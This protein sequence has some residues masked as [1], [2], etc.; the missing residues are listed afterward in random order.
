MLVRMNSSQCVPLT[1]QIVKGIRRLV[2]ERALRPGTCLPSIRQFAAA[3]NVSKVTVVS[4]YD[5]LVAAGYI[6]SRKNAGFFV[7]RPSWLD[8][9]ADAD[10]QPARI[11][12]VLWLLRKQTNQKCFKHR[13]GS[14]WLPHRWMEESGLARA[15]RELGRRE[16][17]GLDSGYGDPLGYAPLRVHVTR[18]LAELGI[19]ACS[20]QVLLTG[21]IT[22]GI[23]LLARFL[24]RPGD[25]VLVDDPG[26]YQWFAH[27]RALGATVHGVRWTDAGPDLEQLEALARAHQPRLFITTPIVQNP[28]GRSISQRTAFRLLQLAERHNFFIVEDDAAAVFHPATPPRLASLDQLNRVV[29]VNSFS[30]FLSPRLRV[31]F[32]A[33]HRDLVRDLADLKLVTQSA[34]SEYTERLICEV[35]DQGNY[36][37]FRIRLLERIQKARNTA[38]RRLEDLGFGPAEDRTH[39]LFAWLEV[40]GIAD[41]TAVAEAAIERSMLLAP[42]ALFRPNMELSSKMR[43]N[44]AFCQNDGMFR[45]LEA[46]L[47]TA[48]RPCSR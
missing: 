46:L 5:Q 18:R 37:K 21:G 4:A 45:E 12:D 35:I 19:E 43:F 1:E 38:V 33:G 36:R 10:P 34:S 13:P 2:D 11:S 40:P 24:I 14:G 39:G 23:D 29:L 26:F 44:V 48:A 16:V 20:N 41:T 42:G 15:M 8:E 47:E 27:M 32:L 25:V 30:K 7:N 22:G 17:D 3:H 6:Q 28:T 9:P 31:G